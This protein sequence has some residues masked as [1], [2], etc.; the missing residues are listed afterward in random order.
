MKNFK[1]LTI[2]FIFLLLQTVVT[3][4][5]AHDAAEVK[6]IAH[7]EKLSD[8][9]D[10]FQRQ[11]GIR[12]VYANSVVD[13]FEVLVRT[14]DSPYRTLKKILLAT[15]LDFIEKSSD[16]WVIVSKNE[17]KDLPAT[18]FGMVVD[19]EDRQPVPGANVMFVDR[20]MGTTADTHGRFELPPISPGEYQILVKRIGYVDEW[21]TVFLVGNSRRR[22]TVELTPKPIDTPEI[23]VQDNRIARTASSSLAKQKITRDELKLPPVANDGEIFEI[24]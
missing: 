10:E 9:L 2:L 24:I 14:E 1:T 20:Q 4:L 13:S 23:I 8:V 21:M 16:L 12:L 18:L 17:T 6:I 3:S 19:A 11:S 22:T 15:P 7:Q 5:E